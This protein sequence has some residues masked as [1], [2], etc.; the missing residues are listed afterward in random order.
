M[1][2]RHRLSASSV[3]EAVALKEYVHCV[4][5]VYALGCREKKAKPLRLELASCRHLE[6]IILT[7]ATQAG[8][9]YGFPSF[10]LIKAMKAIGGCACRGGESLCI[11][12]HQAKNIFK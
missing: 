4:L 9:N 12:L 3:S 1:P 5:V 2:C 10:L 7:H 8:K 11:Y 6:I